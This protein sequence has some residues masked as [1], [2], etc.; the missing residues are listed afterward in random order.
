ML[1]ANWNVQCFNSGVF[2]L[3]GSV[4]PWW[5]VEKAESAGSS[6]VG[7]T[8]AAEV[9]EAVAPA[10]EYPLMPSQVP[11]GVCVPRWK[12]PVLTD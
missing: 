12:T 3:S 6:S 2:N 7:S 5:L 10:A 1:A 11:T 8:A 4:Y 9:P